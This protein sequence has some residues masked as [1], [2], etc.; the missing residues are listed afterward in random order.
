MEVQYD[1]FF[2]NNLGHPDGPAVE[3]RTLRHENLSSYFDHLNGLA[4]CK[5]DG[6]VQFATVSREVHICILERK[7]FFITPIKS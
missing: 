3:K 4:C 1:N 5:E 6:S 7:V 2:A